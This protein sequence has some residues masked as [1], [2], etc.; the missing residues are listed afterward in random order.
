MNAFPS[1]PKKIPC[2]WLYRSLPQVSHA[3]PPRKVGKLNFVA[4]R[5]PNSAEIR[6][7]IGAAGPGHRRRS[8]S[9]RGRPDLVVRSSATYLLSARCCLPFKDSLPNV[10]VV[11]SERGS[12]F[13]LE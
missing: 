6:T 10:F 5:I 4:T 1:Q 7:V 8:Y 13:S 3:W 11:S 9:I 12:Y 2:V